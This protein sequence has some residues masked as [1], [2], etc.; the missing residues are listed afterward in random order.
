MSF[1]KLDI[2]EVLLYL[3]NGHLLYSPYNNED[4]SP[5]KPEDFESQSELYIMAK[6]PNSD[7]VWLR[8]DTEECHWESISE[9]DLAILTINDWYFKKDKSHSSV[10]FAKSEL[11]FCVSTSKGIK[12]ICGVTDYKEK[13]IK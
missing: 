6:L 9:I 8:K 3:N 11:D 10:K 13:D 12:R 7:I 2:T 5:C 4:G 1:K